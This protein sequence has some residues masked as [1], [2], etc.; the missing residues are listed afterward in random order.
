VKANDQLKGFLR[1]TYLTTD[2]EIDCSTCLDLV[3]IYVDQELDG[4]DPNPEMP[5]LVQHLAVCRDCFEEY[6]SLRHLAEAER[7]SGI[8]DRDELLRQLHDQE[9]DLR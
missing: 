5:A 2:E 8:P 4:L 9:R 3:P 6:E 7:T 1:S